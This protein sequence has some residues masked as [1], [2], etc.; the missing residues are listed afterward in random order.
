MSIARGAL[1]VKDLVGKM[2]LSARAR[3]VDPGAPAR[4]AFVSLP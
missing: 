1:R 4:P 3:V 2:P